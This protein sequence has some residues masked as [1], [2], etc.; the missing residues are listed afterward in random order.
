MRTTL[1]PLAIDQD[2]EAADLIVRRV[3]EEGR[4]DTN[5]LWIMSFFDEWDKM[6]EAYEK[7][8]GGDGAA[9]EAS[10][11][12]MVTRKALSPEKFKE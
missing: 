1:S 10:Y 7:Y 12:W 11:V 9:G 4:G 5:S 3:G 8:S 2:E 6:I